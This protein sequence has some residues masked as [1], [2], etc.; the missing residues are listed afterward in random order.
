MKRPVFFI[1]LIL[2][3]V[4]LVSLPAG[5]HCGIS[6]LQESS[7]TGGNSN[8]LGDFPGEDLKMQDVVKIITGL[9]CW[10][11]RI[12]LPVLIVFLV[13]AGFRFMAA[14]SNPPAF[15][16]AKKNLM[17]TLIGALVMLGVYVIIATVANAVGITDFSFIPL[18][19]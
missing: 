8:S 10:A 15:E 3:T 16:K 2:L 6:A 5:R 14:R 1:F 11:I 17:Y 12:I 19:C 13:M 9:A 4:I 18:V 7:S